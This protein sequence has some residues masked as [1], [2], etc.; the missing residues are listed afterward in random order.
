M[1][2]IDK[3]YTLNGE[4]ILKDGHTMFLKDI[5]KDLNTWRNEARSF[6]NKNA[7]LLKEIGKLKYPEPSSLTGSGGKG[8]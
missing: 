6:R 1:I 4:D 2:V 3:L 7:L 5:V 8:E